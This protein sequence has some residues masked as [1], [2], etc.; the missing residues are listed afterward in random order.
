MRNE[1]IFAIMEVYC[2]D[3]NYANRVDEYISEYFDD[4]DQDVVP[5][6]LKALENFLLDLPFESVQY[7]LSL[8][9]NSY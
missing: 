8:F 9:P 3:K 7:L 2:I 4:D 5:T 1:E 6:S